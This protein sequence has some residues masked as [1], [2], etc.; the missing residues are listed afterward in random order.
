MNKD[1]VCSSLQGPP[2]ALRSATDQRLRGA[3][4][5]PR[6]VETRAGGRWHGSAQ[7][8]RTRSSARTRD[9]RMAGDWY[10]T[11]NAP[12]SDLSGQIPQ[13]RTPVS[14]VIQAA[15]RP[16]RIRRSAR[17]DNEMTQSSRRSSRPSSFDRICQV[18]HEYPRLG[19]ARYS[20]MWVRCQGCR[21][22]CGNAQ[23]SPLGTTWMASRRPETAVQIRRISRRRHPTARSHHSVMTAAPHNRPWPPHPASRVRDWERK[24]ER[25][26]AARGGQTRSDAVIVAQPKCFDVR[27]RPQAAVLQA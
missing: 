5:R 14:P 13:R 16:R 23:T 15:R 1:L 21:R 27:Q 9:P 12:D 3:R 19:N 25:R 24:W 7:S 20:A 26:S 22:A 17:P 2:V 8:C 10:P 11:K 18:T 6:T 4:R